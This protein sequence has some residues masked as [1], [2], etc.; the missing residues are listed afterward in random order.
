M[1]SIEELN[2]EIAQEGVKSVTELD[3]MINSSP[4]EILES[5]RL[6]KAGTIK[7]KKKKKTMIDS[8][9]S[10]PSPSKKNPQFLQ[11]KKKMLF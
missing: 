6:K 11:N 1:T 2:L 10:I 3:G 9:A 5:K 4:E 8:K 7:K